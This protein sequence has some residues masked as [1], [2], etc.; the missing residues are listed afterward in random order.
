MDE[1]SSNLSLFWP[2]FFGLVFLRQKSFLGDHK[3]PLNNIFIKRGV[4]VMGVFIA[5]LKPIVF[6][7]LS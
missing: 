1:E 3:E 4:I 5:F 7:F 2:L 6:F